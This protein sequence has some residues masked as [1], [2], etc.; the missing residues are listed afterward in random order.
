VIPVALV[1]DH[2]IGFH[3]LTNTERRRRASSYARPC[4]ADSAF[5]GYTYSIRQAAS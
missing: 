2:D 4:V 3:G 1:T 5:A